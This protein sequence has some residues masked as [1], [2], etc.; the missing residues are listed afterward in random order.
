MKI[1]T[2]FLTAASLSFPLEICMGKQTVGLVSRIRHPTCAEMSMWGTVTGHNAG[3][4][5]ASRCSTKGEVH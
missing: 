3:C 5:E 4:Q 2:D 1:S